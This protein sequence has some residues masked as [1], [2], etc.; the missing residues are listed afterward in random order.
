MLQFILPWFA[1]FI[2]LV[3]GWS[4]VGLFGFMKDDE[5][6]YLFGP[7]FGFM[8]ISLTGFLSSKLNF[9]SLVWIV[10]VIVFFSFIYLMYIKNS[11]R[12]F[13][14]N[15]LRSAPFLIWVAVSFLQY[16]YLYFFGVYNPGSDA[17]W[18]IYNV[19]NV[20]QSDQMFSWHQAHFFLNDFEYLKHPFSGMVDLYD[21]T[22][23]GGYLVLFLTKI[24]HLNLD[25]VIDPASTPGLTFYHYQ[26]EPLKFYLIFWRLLNNFYLFGIAAIVKALLGEG[27]VRASLILTASSAMFNLLSISVWAKLLSLYLMCL[28]ITLAVKKTRPVLVTLLCIFSF[29]AHGAVIPFLIGLGVYL[30]LEHGFQERS[31]KLNFK[32]LLPVGIYALGSIIGIGLWFFAVKMSGSKQPLANGYLYNA[33]WVELQSAKLEDIIHRFYST[34]TWAELTF[35]PV[36][37]WFT[38]FTGYPEIYFEFDSNWRRMLA[39]GSMMYQFLTFSGIIGLI[40]L[41]WMFRGI[42]AFLS[43]KWSTFLFGLYVFPTVLM[44]LVFRV[45]GILSTRIICFYHTL[46][47]LFVIY[48]YGKVKLS[49][50]LKKILLVL[51]C[52]EGVLTALFSDRYSVYGVKVESNPLWRFSNQD[53]F[54]ILLLITSWLFFIGFILKSDRSEVVE[55]ADKDKGGQSKSLLMYTAFVVMVLTVYGIFNIQF[56]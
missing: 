13:L 12:R 44:G 49:P 14:R 54:L 24:F 27:R 33:G 16:G 11:E 15:H 50:H 25:F 19:T 46:G 17:T 34:R 21:R 28:A 10:T 7:A 45:P 3:S 41:P 22:H 38:N 53:F 2:I 43:R 30:I 9:H 18:S 48:S 23:L 20:P 35:L 40:A 36:T 47:I 6:R 26:A 29:H 56:F 1:I 8:L 55:A 39:T 32:R 42:F 4:V 5:D 52:L 31:F 51:M 37:N